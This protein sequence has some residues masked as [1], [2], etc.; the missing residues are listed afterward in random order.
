MEWKNTRKYAKKY[1]CFN[2]RIINI[3][4]KGFIITRLGVVI[5]KL[6]LKQK[7]SKRVTKHLKGNF[8][9]FVYCTYC[10]DVYYLSCFV[11]KLSLLEKVVTRSFYFP[12]KMFH[13]KNQ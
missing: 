9:S 5:N 8:L 1:T 13:K 10:C 4:F 12:I 3:K 6:K 2:T 7:Q 11:V